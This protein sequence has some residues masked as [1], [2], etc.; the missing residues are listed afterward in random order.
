MS[1]GIFAGVIATQ[2]FALGLSQLGTDGSNPSPSSGE[3]LSLRHLCPLVRDWVA[4]SHRQ[5]HRSVTIDHRCLGISTAPFRPIAQL[6]R[7][8]IGDGEGKALAAPTIEGLVDPQHSIGLE[9]T[10]NPQRA[11]IDRLK[12]KPRDERQHS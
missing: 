1:A 7:R 6:A 8:P 11:G 12:A 4:E 3:G 10:C 2:E 5:R 9:Q